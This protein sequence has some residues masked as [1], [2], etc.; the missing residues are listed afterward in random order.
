MRALFPRASLAF[1]Q[2]PRIG[3]QDS[4]VT[5]RGGSIALGQVGNRGWQ[6]STN[7]RDK[8]AVAGQSPVPACQAALYTV[9]VVAPSSSG[10]SV[11]SGSLAV[12]VGGGVVH[13]TT[14]GVGAA[15]HAVSPSSTNAITMPGQ[16]GFIGNL[17]C[18]FDAGLLGFPEVRMVGACGVW[19]R[20]PR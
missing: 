11:A 7:R 8:D 10:G 1:G 12:G 2:H 20:A 13:G 4:V 15:V 6:K 17:L 18:A 9:K 3:Q 5:G 19:P 14:V 16:S